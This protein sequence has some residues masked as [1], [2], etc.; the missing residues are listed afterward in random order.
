MTC[1]L[2]PVKPRLGD[3][4]DQLGNLT[5]SGE[6]I[7]SA[8]LV[9][10][11][12]RL[13]EARQALGITQETAAITIGV[14]RTAIV[15]IEAGN[16]SISTVEL[17]GLAQLYHRPLASF[18]ADE[19]PQDDPLVALHR[20]SPEAKSDPD[21]ASQVARCVELCREG[22]KLAASLGRDSRTGP[23]AYFVP[24]PG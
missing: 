20:L 15:H 23:P 13:R 18:F 19:L 22:W 21:V 7:M 6:W 12:Q 11:G 10:L 14:P 8:S 16:R 1:S 24:P 9:V 2:P 5:D 3:H 4:E 17:A